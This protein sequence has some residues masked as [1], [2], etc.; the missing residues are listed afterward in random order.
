M[1]LFFFFLK[2]KILPASIKLALDDTLSFILPNR[3]LKEIRDVCVG[4]L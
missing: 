1:L 2:L 3:S 4:N